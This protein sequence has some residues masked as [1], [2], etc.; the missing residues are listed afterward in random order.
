MMHPMMQRNGDQAKGGVL[1]A[2]S[3]HARMLK[4]WGKGCACEDAGE[5]VLEVGEWV[6]GRMWKRTMQC[7]FGHDAVVG[8]SL[9]GRSRQPR[10][11]AS[12]VLGLWMVE[13]LVEEIVLYALEIA[14][15]SG[16]CWRRVLN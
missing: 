13:W 16:G 9:D 12:A 2:A 4:V 5:G 14:C 8:K 6:M 15:R 7:W 1:G 10:L 3:G 11:A